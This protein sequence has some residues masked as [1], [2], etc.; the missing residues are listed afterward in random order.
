VFATDSI[1]DT[2]ASFDLAAQ[3]VTWVAVVFLG[4]IAVSLHIRLQ[5]LERKDFERHQ[6][7]PFGH[8][9]GRT[10]GEV[11]DGATPRPQPRLVLFLSSSCPACERLLAELQA[12]GWDLPAAVVWTTPV[13]GQTPR[14]RPHV[15]LVADGPRIS[16]ALGIRVTPFALVASD[17]GAIIRASPVNSLESLRDVLKPPHGLAAFSLSR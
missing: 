17:G 5:R 6:T 11:L 15:T 8:L 7:A 14:V 9:L 13:P 3:F 12:P 2:R 16:A 4:L 1:L 10:L